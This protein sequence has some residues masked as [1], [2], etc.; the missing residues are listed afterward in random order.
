MTGKAVALI[1]VLGGL[2]AVSSAALFG[3]PPSD[4][5]SL[6]GLT[7]MASLITGAVGG[8]VLS[9]LR[10][11]SLATQTVCVAITTVATVAVGASAAAG[12][13]FISSHDLAALWVI[14]FAAATIGMIVALVLGRRA[15]SAIASL[16]RAAQTV[17]QGQPLTEVDPSLSGEFALL[18][19]ALKDMSA[20]LQESL[21][22]ERALDSSRREL[23][24]WVSHDLR[25]PL[26][27]IRAMTEA[28][29]DKVVVDPE[30][31]E[32]YYRD[33]RKEAE[34]LSDLVDDLFELSRI[35]AGALRLQIEKASLE[36]L[37]SDA[38]AASAGVARAKGVTLTGR[39]TGD[40]REIDLSTPEMA[41]AL[42]NLM[43]NAIRHTPSDGSVQVEAG[44][45]EDHAYLAVVDGCGGIPASD[46]ERV[47][48]V[49]YRG[50]SARSPDGEGG[51]GLGLAIARGIVEAHRGDIAVQN[52][53]QG[54]RFVVRLPV[55][56]PV[57]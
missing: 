17:G 16:K 22:R 11:R 29:E 47:F 13:M 50:A 45:E 30:T 5:Y 42:R 24:A 21:E 41:R 55:S 6:V 31:V 25:T 43:E 33:L 19:A 3:I 35:N 10:H 28:L 14:L 2:L 40:V 15:T 32:K 7:V 57:E 34:R 23:V 20:K 49:A 37:V 38:L 36:D 54:C 51:A 27:G 26:A 12:Q 44:I 9:R 46:I 56:Q 4:L 53:D 39:L 18:G 52:V 48:D 8:L 1:V